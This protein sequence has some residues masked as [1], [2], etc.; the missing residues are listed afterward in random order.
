MKLTTITGYALG[1][2]AVVVLA[3]TAPF[4]GVAAALHGKLVRRPRLG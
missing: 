4:K 1:I 2:S 3:V